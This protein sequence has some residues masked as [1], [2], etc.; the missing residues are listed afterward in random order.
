[1]DQVV[2][3]GEVKVRE[4]KGS[5]KA[6]YEHTGVI[7]VHTENR[8][9]RWAMREIVILHEIAHHLTKGDGH[10]A[11]FAGTLLD[12]VGER[13]APE[14]ALLLTDAYCMHGVTWKPSLRVA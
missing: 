10:G 7:A 4:R 12:L 6:H 11:L 1:V 5:A 14:V 2:G 8:G 9:Q 3:A 13:I